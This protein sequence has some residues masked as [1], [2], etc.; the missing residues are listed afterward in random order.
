MTAAIELSTLEDGTAEGESLARHQTI[1]DL[2]NAYNASATDIRRASA[3]L[4]LA[5]S[6][7][8]EAFA[9]ESAIDKV[10]LRTA[11]GRA[12][13]FNPEEAIARLRLEV[14]AHLVERLEVRRFLSVR[15]A[16]ELNRMLDDK[17]AEK[18]PDITVENVLAFA[19]GLRSQVNDMLTEAVDEVFEWL[20]PR[21]HTRAGQLKTNTELEVGRKV[22]LG[23]TVERA[24]TGKGFRVDY[25]REQ[26]V[27]A[28]EN[29]FTA[30]DG[31]GSIT[32]THHSRLADA[33]GSSGASGRGE[34]EYF[35][36]RCFGNRNVHLEFKRLDLLKKFNAIAGGKRLR[37]KPEE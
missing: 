22:I 16:E 6:R 5:T 4:D 12:V 17:S 23:Y 32:K 25:H 26:N 28:L 9:N 31:K 14:W 29:V 30:L 36:F 15:R 18:L 19:R 10:H 2:V 7:L 34:T 8:D 21:P 33:I 13:E 35:R 37:P 3:L 1:V 24:W 20:R 11:Y 27:R